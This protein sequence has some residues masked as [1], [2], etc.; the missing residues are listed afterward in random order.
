[1]CLRANKSGDI[2]DGWTGRFDEFYAGLEIGGRF[3]GECDD[4]IRSQNHV[5]KMLAES[6]GDLKVFDDGMAAVHRF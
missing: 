2:A 1:M 5:G 6:V 4:D 3:A